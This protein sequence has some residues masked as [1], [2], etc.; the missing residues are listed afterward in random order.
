M[1]KTETKKFGEFGALNNSV[2]FFRNDSKPSL[3]GSERLE[4][5]IFRKDGSL[6]FGEM[7]VPHWYDMRQSAN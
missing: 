2:I 4:P 7:G 1:N 3:K 6:G 5:Q